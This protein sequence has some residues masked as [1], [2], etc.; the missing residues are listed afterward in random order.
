[1]SDSSRDP[2]QKFAVIDGPL[3]GSDFSHAD[4]HFYA[5]ILPM[6]GL[7]VKPGA[8]ARVL[9]RLRRLEDESQVWSMASE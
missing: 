3:Q 8:K 7:A 5:A 1:M 9:Y 6:P 4:D 2:L